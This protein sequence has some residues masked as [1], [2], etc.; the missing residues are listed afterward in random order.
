MQKIGNLGKEREKKEKQEERDISLSRPSS[1][2][3]YGFITRVLKVHV[4][5]K[6]PTPRVLVPFLAI[7]VQ[8]RT[9]VGYHALSISSLYICF[10]AQSVFSMDGSNAL[11][12]PSS[13]LY[14]RRVEGVI[15]PRASSGPLLEG[16]LPLPE[17]AVMDLN[18]HRRYATIST[19]THCYSGT[20]PGAR[21]FQVRMVELS[22]CA[23]T[24]MKP[25]SPG[26]QWLQDPRSQV[27]GFTTWL[28]KIIPVKN[29]AFERL[30]PFTPSSRDQV[31][32]LPF[33]RDAI[34]T[35]HLGSVC[36]STTRTSKVC[37]INFIYVR[38][39][40][41]TVLP[42]IWRQANPYIKSKQQVQNSGEN[43]QRLTSRLSQQFSLASNIHA[44]SKGSGFCY[45]TL[46]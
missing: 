44:R 5:L 31:R 35:T 37:W 20:W 46:S 12:F 27:Y 17:A 32:N 41:P 33:T 1:R 15:Q 39:T 38:S 4:D 18:L 2:R 24:H 21:P 43:I 25:P 14:S 45:I 34:H 11:Q 22:R 8:V 3:V 7:L 6:E 29:F 9:M 40:Q 13:L 10:S 28:E 26:V 30:L 19:K 42:Y 36:C 23:S 16:K